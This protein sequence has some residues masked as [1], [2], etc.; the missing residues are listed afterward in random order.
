[1]IIVLMWLLILM[2][3]NNY[4]NDGQIKKYI[5]RMT[6]RPYDHSMY[7]TALFMSCNI[8]FG[9]PEECSNKCHGFLNFESN[10]F[11]RFPVTRIMVNWTFVPNSIIFLNPIELDHTYRDTWFEMCTHYIRMKGWKKQDLKPPIEIQQIIRRW[12]VYSP[13]TLMAYSIIKTL[14]YASLISQL[15]RYYPEIISNGIVSEIMHQM[16]LKFIQDELK[17]LPNGTMILDKSGRTLSFDYFKEEIQKFLPF[18]IPFMTRDVVKRKAI[19]DEFSFVSS[20]FICLK[21]LPN[22][23]NFEIAVQYVKTYISQLHMWDKK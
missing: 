12:Y 22:I 15:G 16:A 3:K 13:H 2:Y 17:T 8:C 20:N 5:L 14:P 11:D 7:N 18:L 9:H 21:D 10:T 4:K 1:M 23:S 6:Q 19:I